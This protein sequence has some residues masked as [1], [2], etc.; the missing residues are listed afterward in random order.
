MKLSIKQIIYGD[1]IF[2][3]VPWVLKKRRHKNKKNHIRQ[4]SKIKIKKSS[5]KKLVSN[6]TFG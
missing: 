1:K 2:T 5:P 4:F 6:Q 3:K